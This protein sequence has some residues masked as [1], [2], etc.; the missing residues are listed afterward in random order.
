MPIWGPDPMPIDNQG[1]DIELGRRPLPE[2]RD[3]IRS[4]LRGRPSLMLALMG[5]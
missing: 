3:Q 5:G 4:Y 2:L 1:A